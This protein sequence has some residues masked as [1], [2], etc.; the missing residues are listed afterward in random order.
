LPQIKIINFSFYYN[1]LNF[2][3]LIFFGSQSVAFSLL[4]SPLVN[5]TNCNFIN[6]LVAIGCISSSV[7]VSIIINNCSFS[8]NQKDLWLPNKCISP[9]SSI[10]IVKSTFTDSGGISSQGPFW[11]QIYNSTFQNGRI[12]N[13]SGAPALI[14]VS[15]TVTIN[16][17]LFSGY[18]T[19]S[20]G[21]C[22]STLSS[23]VAI[24]NTDFSDCMS[25]S[26]GGALSL[27]ETTLDLLNEEFSNCQ[28]SG[29]G[30]AI[31]AVGNSLLNVKS[32]IFLGNNATSDGGAFFLQA[33]SMEVFKSQFINNTATVG[34]AYA[35]GAGGY[36]KEQNCTFKGNTG[37]GSC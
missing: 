24:A 26:N 16:F 29:N 32:C 25:V 15:T 12:S 17:S 14:V 4:A 13:S 28:S 9:S 20:G 5:F 10:S 19:A 21:A 36:V 8:Q 30:G 37:G 27:S 1:N 23:T 18:S 2:S 3:D 7:Q 31:F 35:C 34:G 33:S 22:I 11:M 6:N